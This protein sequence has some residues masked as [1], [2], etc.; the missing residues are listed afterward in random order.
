MYERFAETVG[1]TKEFVLKLDGTKRDIE[2]ESMFAES[3]CEFFGTRGADPAYRKKFGAVYHIIDRVIT[4]LFDHR[5]A[6]VRI[7]LGS[8][9]Y[10]IS[11]SPVL[12]D[13]E[14]L[15]KRK[16]AYD[17]FNEQSLRRFRKFFGPFFDMDNKTG[18]LVCARQL[19]LSP[20]KSVDAI[21]AQAV[22]VH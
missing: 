8:N 2:E 13:L 5:P 12:K 4:E 9:G 16:P 18:A 7:A 20:K 21:V 22:E 19:D 17:I 10:A 3:F 15:L 14:L 1:A 6:E 11:Y